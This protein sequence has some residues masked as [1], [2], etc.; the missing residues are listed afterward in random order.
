[1][2]LTFAMCVYAQLFYV[3]KFHI[4]SI[5]QDSICIFFCSMSFVNTKKN[6]IYFICY[7]LTYTTTIFIY[8]LMMAIKVTSNFDFH[9]AYCCEGPYTQVVGD[10][11]QS[12]HLGKILCGWR[13]GT[14]RLNLMV[15]NYSL[16]LYQLRLP[17][18]EY[19]SYICLHYCQYLAL[20]DFMYFFPHSGG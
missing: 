1:M 19:K 8:L 4:S 9:K 13:D 14:S 17:A 7:T 5:L 3:F 6:M 15:S 18:E 2:L 16:K 10:I 12:T 11:V 20:L